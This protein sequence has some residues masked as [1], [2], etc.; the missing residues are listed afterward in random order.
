[1][2]VTAEALAAAPVE[3]VT[4]CRLSSLAK[5]VLATV[6]DVQQHPNLE[7]HISNHTVLTAIGK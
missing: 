6:Y 5:T 3:M 2:P 1:M 4:R 7:D